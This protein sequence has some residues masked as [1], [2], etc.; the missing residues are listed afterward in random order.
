MLG[1]PQHPQSSSFPERQD[2]LAI[3]HQSL[4][5]K[6][7]TWDPSRCYFLTLLREE[8]KSLWNCL[9]LIKDTGALLLLASVHP[10]FTML[11]YDAF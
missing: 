9:V 2:D 7:T 11:T 6:G 4:A 5:E 1:P 8:S 10:N 3:T